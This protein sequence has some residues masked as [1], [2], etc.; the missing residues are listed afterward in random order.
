MRPIDSAIMKL[1][2]LLALALVP[3]VHAYSNRVFLIRHGEKP[4][5]D[6]T[7][8]HDAASCARVPAETSPLQPA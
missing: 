7:S 8:E 6:S 5:D 4:A 2:T 1:T 3:A